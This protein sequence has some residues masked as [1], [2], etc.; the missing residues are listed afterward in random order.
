MKRWLQGLFPL[1]LLGLLLVIL[2][3]FGP[4]GVFQAAFPP[5]EELTL[6]RID[7]PR[8]HEMVVHVVNGARHRGPGH[9]RRC[10]LAVHD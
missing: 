10:P 8:P 2:F 7:L 1:L 5:V 9:G 4:L 6:D 3:S